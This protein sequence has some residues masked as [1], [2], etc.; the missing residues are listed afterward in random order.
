[1]RPMSAMG[2]LRTGSCCSKADR[3]LSGLERRA[4]PA[5]GR[6]GWKADT[7]LSVLEVP[8]QSRGINNIAAHVSDEG[9]AD[10]VFVL[11]PFLQVS[12]RVHSFGLEQPIGEFLS[13]DRATFRYEVVNVRGLII[14]EQYP[15]TSPALHRPR[16]LERCIQPF[17]SQ[18]EPTGSEGMS[19][20]GGRQTYRLDCPPRLKAAWRPLHSMPMLCSH[21]STCPGHCVVIGSSVGRIPYA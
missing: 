14:K 11:L 6:Q 2:R 20:T 19:A 16:A 4:M 18:R 21:C 12:A 3:R 15:H 7:R 1:M 9:F 17:H 10:A 13:S 8:L 5:N